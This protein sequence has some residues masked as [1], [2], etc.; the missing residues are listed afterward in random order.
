LTSGRL[1]RSFRD[2]AT[3]RSFRTYALDWLFPFRS[4]EAM[5]SRF[6]LRR[7]K[8]EE[9]LTSAA[10]LYGPVIA[11][12]K[13]GESLPPIGAAR[14]YVAGDKWRE[15]IREFVSAA[16][17]VIL[18]L[19]RTRGLEWE[20]RTIAEL[21][22]VEKLVIVVPPVARRDLLPRW[23][24]LVS[25][26]PEL[27]RVP[28]ELILDQALIVRISPLGQPVVITSKSRLE[29]DYDR[30]MWY[31]AISGG[32]SNAPEHPAPSRLPPLEPSLRDVKPGRMDAPQSV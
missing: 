2:D 21:G 31:A 15:R 8:L 32:R 6:L 12:G 13:P 22:S 30:A 18:V 9:T 20:M 5:T 7:I 28:E 19:G 4:V 1:L 27:G 29:D 26:F 17:A 16:A 11:I 14:D 25:I 3:T 10:S 24:R 23:E